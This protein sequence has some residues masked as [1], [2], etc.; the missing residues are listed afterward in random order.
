MAGDAKCRE[1]ILPVSADKYILDRLD[2]GGILGKLLREKKNIPMA[3]KVTYMPEGLNVDALEDYG[4]GNPPDGYGYTMEWLIVKIQK[5]LSLSE[6][7]IILLQHRFAKPSDPWIERTGTQINS[8][9][10]EVYLSI[11]SEQGKQVDYIEERISD[12][13]TP[14]FIGI[15]SSL[16]NEIELLPKELDEATLLYLV[17]QTEHLIVGAYDGCGYIICSFK[18]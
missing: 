5:F 10:D 13:E 11:S 9:N 17:K 16:P 8:F 12:A 1:Y 4:W 14:F 2:N 7:R 18:N 15:M 6:K 3:E